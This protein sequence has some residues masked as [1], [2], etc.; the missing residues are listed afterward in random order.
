M[1]MATK[2]WPSLAVGF[3]CVALATAACSSSS[4]STSTSSASSSASSATS[5]AASGSPASTANLS[6]APVVIGSIYPINATVTSFP[7][8]QYMA[9]I[10]VNVVNAAGGIKGHPLKWVHCDNKDDPNVAATCANQ[11]INEDKVRALVESVGLE[12][13]VPWPLIK[14]ANIINWFDV[15]TWPDD[16]KSSLSY[17]AG[18][19]IY[20]F[21]NLGTLVKQGE[22]KKVDCMAGTS[23][24]TGPICGAAKASLAAKGITDFNE[25]TW[26]LTNTAFQPYAEKVVASGAD[27]VVIVGDDAIT[28]PVIQ[29]LA[30]AGAK[31]TVLEPS[32]SV[33]TQSM[34]TAKQNSVP[35]RVAASWAVDAAK[36]PARQQMLAN[37]QKYSSAVGAP[38]DLNTVDDNAVNM[39]EGILSL[40]AVMNGAKSLA[41]ADLQAYIDSHPIA[42]GLA[43]PLDWAKPGPVAGNPRIIQVYATSETL[44][45]SGALVSA[46]NSWNS[47]FPGTTALTC[48]SSSS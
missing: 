6:G 40:A 17:P 42:T 48:C 28:A 25:I 36:F 45:S 39:Y 26:P 4:S 2:K 29:A 11:V 47:G 20:S 46:S 19:G 5:A 7:Q 16:G 22:F 41:T 44:D 23:V 9:D 18:S 27:A 8:L 33:G 13:N 43:P 30:Q 14:K 34:Q 32:T 12:S 21:Q 35:L 15:P 38:A 31:V 3:A 37:V 24:L 10:A 1:M